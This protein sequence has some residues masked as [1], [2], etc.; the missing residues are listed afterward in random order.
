MKG[1]KE[2]I[3]AFHEMNDCGWQYWTSIRVGALEAMTKRE[4]GK[5]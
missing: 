4:M 1:V 5:F 3:P 2:K